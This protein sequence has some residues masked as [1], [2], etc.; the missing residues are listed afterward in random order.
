MDRIHYIFPSTG[1][2]TFT[3]PINVL[4]TQS[5]FDHTFG[6]D[7]IM[8]QIIKHSKRQCATADTDYSTSKVFTFCNLCLLHIFANSV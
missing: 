5:S 7:P 2:M 4:D 6:L 3:G 1:V 8:I